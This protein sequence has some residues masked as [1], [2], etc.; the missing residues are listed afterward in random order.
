MGQRP[1]KTRPQQGPTLKGSNPGGVT[2]VLR[3][4]AQGNSTPSGSGNERGAFRGRCPISANLTLRR[5]RKPAWPGAIIWPTVSLDPPCAGES[6]GEKG[7]WKY[8]SSPGRGDVITRDR[9]GFL[10]RPPR[11]A[12]GKL[13]PWRRGRAQV[14]APAN[15]HSR[16]S[17]NPRTITCC[18][19]G[20]WASSP[21]K[22]G[23]TVSG[24]GREVAGGVI[25]AH[26][27]MH[28]GRHGKCIIRD[29]PWLRRGGL[30]GTLCVGFIPQHRTTNVAQTLP[31]A[32]SLALV[33]RCPRLQSCALAGHEKPT[34]RSY[35]AAPRF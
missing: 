20:G 23:S 2:P 17:G 27:G 10:C 32:L 14:G 22:R 29:L 6:R 5:V 34:L 15:C 24:G 18:Q 9:A 1:R 12:Q 11:R 7:K 30:W 31:S 13:W 3:V 26:A 35:P 28:V 19:D 16:E 8:F 25:P 4:A 21:R 33:G